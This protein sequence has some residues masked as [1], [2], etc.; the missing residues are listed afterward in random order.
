MNRLE[1]PKFLKS[2]PVIWGLSLETLIVISFSMLIGSHCFNLKE[3]GILFLSFSIY[4]IMF[5]YQKKFKKNAWYFF[6]KRRK[7]LSWKHAMRKIK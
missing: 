2:H 6:L 4:F 3:D 7:N 5:S 1:F